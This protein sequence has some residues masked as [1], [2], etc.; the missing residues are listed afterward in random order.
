MT[1]AALALQ[2]AQARDLAV[3]LADSV[4]V[5]APAGSGKTTLLVQRY[6][7]LLTEVQVPESILALTFTRRAAQEMRERVLAA[8]DGARAEE[9]LSG[10]N[11]KTYRLA[12]AANLHLD[13]RQLD[14]A[15]HPSRLRIETIDS[16]NAWLAGQLPITAGAGARL[17]TLEDPR[18]LYREAARRSLAY[19]ERDAMGVAVENL[20][21]LD[22][23]RWRSLV[24]LISGMLGARDRWLPLLA[25]GL[26]AASALSAT[27]LQA[28][29][30]RFDEDLALLVRRGLEVLVQEL[31]REKIA[32]LAQVAR[33]AARR[34][35]GK[36]DELAAW[37]DAAAPLR[38]E[39]HEMARWQGICFLLLTKEGAYRA[40]LTIAEG[41]PP[42]HADKQTMLDLIAEVQRNPALLLALMTVR[43]LPQPAY[44]DSQ[45]QRVRDV[46]QVMVLAAAQLDQLFREHGAVD[47][48]AVALAAR[49]ALGSVDA[50]TDLNLRLDYQLRH[51]LLDEFQDTSSA[52]L[53][54]VRLLTA[55]WTQ[56]DGRSLFCVGDPMQSI[57]GFRQAEVR[58]FLELADDGIG[59]VRFNLQRL[60]SNFRSAPAVVDWVNACFCEIM[61]RRD[62][63]E[64]GAIAFRPS[65]AAAAGAS[66]TG[67]TLIGYASPAAEAQH[68]AAMIAARL[69]QHPDWRVAILVRAKTHAQ[70][71]AAC[72]RASGVSFRAVAIEP[73]SERP[74]VRDLIA[75]LRAVVHW[76]DR[77]AWFA[78]LRAPWCGLTL[79]DLWHLGQGEYLL[80]DR[81]REPAVLKLLSADG[82][83]R[84]ERLATVLQEAR[85]ARGESTITRW[86]ERIWLALGGPSCVTQAH[87]LEHAAAFFARLREV[88]EAGLPDVTELSAS[89]EDLFADSDALSRVEIMTI[90]KAKG[91]EFDMV[92]VPALERVISHS[93]DQLLLAHEFARS[94]RDGM[95]MAA[96]PPVGSQTD[97]LFNFLQQ[98][99]RDAAA[100]EAQRLL[101]VACT[102]AKFHLHLSACM[103]LNEP[104]L[105]SEH[106]TRKEFAPRASSLLATLWPVHREQFI[107]SAVASAAAASAPGTTDLNRAGPLERLPAAWRPPTPGADSAGARPGVAAATR[108]EAVM[109]DWAGETARRIG[110]L[111]HAELQR[112]D[113]A[114]CDAA[115]I[116]A[117]DA[118]YRRWLALRGVPDE[119]LTDASARVIEALTNVLQD[120]RGRWVLHD[121]HSE[122][123]REHALSGRFNG[124]LVRVVFDRSFVDRGTRWVIDYKTSLHSGGGREEFLDREVERY[125]AQLQR[126]ADFA[127]RLGGEPVRVGLYFPLM[128]AWREW[129][130]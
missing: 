40:R 46:A 86:L 59:E 125:R 39:A 51:V 70:A 103:E 79:E 75:L 102:R 6:L 71:L 35:L 24:K 33:A 98:K 37:L 62:D 61:P 14:V 88:E 32:A 34:L 90:H 30:Q 101:Y 100:L 120:D 121:G 49:Q 16:F 42:D 118:H 21:E 69:E 52:Q 31:G 57:Y 11:A 1:E 113:P 104:S 68:I 60:N 66:D 45:W 99:Q 25:G 10:L 92:V 95:V 56:G 80:W 76:G 15:A 119:R 38:G 91:L 9:S 2:D 22:D 122:A 67:V 94:E 63:R 18:L 105:D 106:R 77:V 114:A 72:L 93:N 65:V 82:R 4:L 84:C 115:T 48:P 54:F 27:Q 20:L 13:A 109:F 8:L 55:G 97:L 74:I 81:L 3:D 96:R 58:A 12:R 112:L 127:H 130:A 110:T 116:R 78:V 108:E 83:Q 89:F 17:K 129:S 111:V 41:F 44:S 19:V 5:Q 47:F 29:R 7:R 43:E 73:L 28:V 124:E 128:G 117:R 50:P 85:G 107:A 23:Q 87:E 53:E 126:Y 36:R 26:H 64:R 123:V